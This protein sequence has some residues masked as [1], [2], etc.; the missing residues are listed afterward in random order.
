MRHCRS[1]GQNAQSKKCRGMTSDDDRDVNPQSKWY[2]IIE[3]F[4]NV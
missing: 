1:L 3:K 4:T 2:K